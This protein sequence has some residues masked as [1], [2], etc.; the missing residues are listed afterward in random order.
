M[1]EFDALLLIC[2]NGFVLFLPSFRQSNN[3]IQF[4]SLL[5]LNQAYIRSLILVLACINVLAKKNQ[6]C[7][8]QYYHFG[9]CGPPRATRALR[10]QTK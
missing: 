10:S 5:N 2:Q 7:S 6:A 8:L 1:G 3:Y 9:I 4:E